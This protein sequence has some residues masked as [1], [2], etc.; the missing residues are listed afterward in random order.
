[1]VL[2]EYRWRNTGIHGHCRDDTAVG[3]R[4]ILIQYRATRQE[5]FWGMSGGKCD[6][7]TD[8]LGYHA[9]GL[10]LEDTGT[11]EGLLVQRGYKSRTF[12][13]R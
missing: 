1:M 7:V 10:S 12:F 5:W 2:L 6:R 11:T 3:A 9:I 8:T 4:V 13:C